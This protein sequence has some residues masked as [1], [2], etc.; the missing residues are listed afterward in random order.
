VGRGG[1]ADATRP[2][3]YD[4]DAWRLQL[5]LERDESEPMSL[6][7]PRIESDE[8]PDDAHATASDDD[9]AWWT[10]DEEEAWEEEN[11]DRLLRESNARLR[12]EGYHTYRARGDRA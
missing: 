6:P 2:P 3:D 1:Q 5:A 7:E 12:A 4:E 10:V 8:L 9:E 11:A